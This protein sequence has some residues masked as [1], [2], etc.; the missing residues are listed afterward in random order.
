MAISKLKY[1]AAV[2]SVFAAGVATCA[3]FLLWP[4]SNQL[5]E[6]HDI[7][8]SVRVD[9]PDLS[10]VNPQTSETIQAVIYPYI[11]DQLDSYW[12][13]VGTRNILNHPY[14][15]NEF[16]VGESFVAMV[17]EETPLASLELISSVIT[18]SGKPSII[19]IRIDKRWLNTDETEPDIYTDTFLFNAE[20]G[21]QYH[22]S[23]FFLNSNMHMN[24]PSEWESFGAY[25]AV[26]KFAED[27][28][29][30]LWFAGGSTTLEDFV[31]TDEGILTLKSLGT[32]NQPGE[33][34]E[35]LIPFE[36]LADQLNPCGP[37]GS[38]SSKTLRSD[39]TCLDT[40]SA[41]R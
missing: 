30:R 38:F 11:Q 29:Y 13:V 35:L 34:H 2:L 1:F 37:L 23:D 22:K 14:Y 8:I 41:D 32:I 9:Y 20:T 27:R 40:S 15:P 33:P 16:N 12:E 6:E 10:G 17:S 39:E 4:D 19:S 31:V 25:G 36:Y 21:K 7:D 28:G 24:E 3:V 18:Y 5:V 26:K